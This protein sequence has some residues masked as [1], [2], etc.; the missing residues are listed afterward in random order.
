V[1]SLWS[2]VQGRTK[3]GQQRRLFED[4]QFTR[5]T[6]AITSSA[7]SVMDRDEL[8][9]LIISLKEKFAAGKL[10]LRDPSVLRELSEVR[11]ADDGKVDSATVGSRVRATAYASAAADASREM[12]QLPLQEV[13]NRYF[14]IAQAPSPAPPAFLW[15]C[16]SPSSAPATSHSCRS[17]TAS[18]MYASPRLA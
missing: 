6:S 4:I 16:H 5:I 17:P 18:F 14:E 9:D 10:V 2:F 1:S 7:W 8:H 15:H 11:F 13:Q 12:D 3:S